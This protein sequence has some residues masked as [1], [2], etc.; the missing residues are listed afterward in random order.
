MSRSD[1][2]LS[3]KIEVFLLVYLLAGS[4]GHAESMLQ[5]QTRENA[6]SG[7]DRLIGIAAAPFDE[8]VTARPLVR[9]R[10]QTVAHAEAI[11]G[12]VDA[13]DLSAAGSSASGTLCACLKMLPGSNADLICFK[14]ERFWPQ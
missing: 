14:R 3:G 2:R 1:R 7:Q 4:P 8:A 12:G 13:T 9:G 6:A 10:D 11:I 5:G